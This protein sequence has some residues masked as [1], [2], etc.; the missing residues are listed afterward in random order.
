MLKILINEPDAMF[1]KGMICFLKELF[2]IKLG[3]KCEYV[4]DFTPENIADADVIV[5][6]LRQGE[7]YICF[8]DLRARRKG[9]VIGL[10]DEADNYHKSPSCFADII[11]ILRR[12]TLKEISQKIT[13]TWRSWLMS[14]GFS[15]YKTCSGCRYVTISPQQKEIMAGLYRGL[16]IQEIAIMLR[17]TYKTVAAQKYVVMRKYSLKN[18]HDLL[19]FLGILRDK[20]ITRLFL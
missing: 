14:E 13:A 17:V 18:D 20:S 1:R 6:S 4:T 16:S 3:R 7:R 19:H 15:R 8:P 10:V 5:L 11:Y 12:E 9:I 2:W